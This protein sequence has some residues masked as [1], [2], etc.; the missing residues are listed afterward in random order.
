M[1]NLILSLSLIVSFSNCFF[2]Q[3]KIKFTNS[4]VALYNSSENK[5]IDE[6]LSDNATGYSEYTESYGLY[7]IDLDKKILTLDFNGGVETFVIK[8]SKIVNQMLYITALTPNKKTDNLSYYRINLNSES[9]D[10]DFAHQHFYSNYGMTYGIISQ[11][12]NIIS[13]E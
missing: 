12:I 1:K 13:C 6:I 5:G 2:S 11:N 3:T 7:T 9:S 4:S 10:L 8:Q